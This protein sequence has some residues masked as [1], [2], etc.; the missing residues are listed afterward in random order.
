MIA[1]MGSW[2]LLLW[3]SI[4]G[5]ALTCSLIVVTILI[6]FRH[7]RELPK[8]PIMRTI[9]ALTEELERLQGDIAA[10]QEEVDRLQ[11]DARL[12][13]QT[14]D[15]KDAAQQWLDAHRADLD[16]MQERRAELDELIGRLRSTEAELGEKKGELQAT[17][18]ELA[19]RRTELSGLQE[20][21]DRAKALRDELPGLEG[22]V[23]TLRALEERLTSEVGSMRDEKRSLDEGVAGL[24]KEHSQLSGEIEAKKSERESLL[25]HLEM[26][27]SDVRSEGGGDGADPLSDLW[28]PYFPTR[29]DSSGSS[30][31]DSRLNFVA[32]TLQEQRIRIHER[33][34]KAF[35]TSLKIQDISPLTVLAGVSGTGKSMLPNLY[36]RLMGIHFLQL[37]VQPGWS[38]PQDLFGFYN[39]IEQKYKA[40]GLARA[41]VQFDGFN[42]EAWIRASRELNNAWRGPEGAPALEDQMLLVLLDEMNLARVEYYFSEMLSRLETRRIV[43]ANDASARRQVEVPLGVGLGGRD[44]SLHMGENVLFA[45]T[46]N[47]DESTLSLSDK[48]LD[49]SSVLRFGMPKS[50]VLEQPDAGVLRSVQPLSKSVWSQW[51][52]ARST[53]TDAQLGHVKKIGSIMEQA[54]VPIGHRV[55]QAMVGY[56]EHY[57]G[58]N[59]EQALA[60]Q[61]ELKVLPKL[62]GRDLDALEQPLADLQRL[63]D[64]LRD[65]QLAE[66]IEAGRRRDR[67]DDTFLWAGLDRSELDNG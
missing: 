62:R 56:M 59:V 22:R 42:R 15:A 30:S 16:K 25:K 12:A 2:D 13:Q 29:V 51:L 18:V 17:D 38:S 39:Y 60:D 11:K 37:P 14:I 10:K 34:L 47:E 28:Q 65:P 36:A 54:G 31:E 6:W 45:G 7:H 53:L 58:G 26:L 43:D 27:R 41:L 57:P 40:T 4:V 33:T 5:G 50:F 63:V 46:M 52:E 67:G 21:A 32:Q 20:Q 3:L 49:R 55:A 64:D 1:S 44:V 8:L 19:K 35:H 9:E 66:A 24:R 23:G 48:V 61:I